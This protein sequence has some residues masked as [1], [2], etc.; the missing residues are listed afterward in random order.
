MKVSGAVPPLF[1]MSL[2][3][4]PRRISC[5]YF[6]NTFR[7]IFIRRTVFKGFSC[8]KAYRR[9]KNEIKKGLHFKGGTG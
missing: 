8:V 1:R 2:L 4:A 6:L 5:Y 3:L 9:G 7:P